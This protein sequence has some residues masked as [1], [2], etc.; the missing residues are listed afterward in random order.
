MIPLLDFSMSSIMSTA[1]VYLICFATLKYIS[2]TM[3][4]FDA[5][6]VL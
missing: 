5:N 1:M 6:S 2:N 3:F 4:G